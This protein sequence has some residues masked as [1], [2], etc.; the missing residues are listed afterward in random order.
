MTAWEM[1]VTFL[2]PFTSPSGLGGSKTRVN[3]LPSPERAP[4]QGEKIISNPTRG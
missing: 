2:P 4:P 3:G 1:L